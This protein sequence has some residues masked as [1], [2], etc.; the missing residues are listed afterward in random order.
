MQD[1]KSY[2]SNIMQKFYNHYNV[3]TDTALADKMMVSRSAVAQWRYKKTIPKKILSKYDY[4]IS[5]NKTTKISGTGEKVEV[6]NKKITIKENEKVNIESNYIIDLQKDKIQQQAT[7]II[8][9]KDALKRKQAE[10][11]HWEHLAY[12]FIASVTLKRSGIKFARVINSVSNLKKQSEIL[13]YSEKELKVLWD[14]GSQYTMEKHPIDK[15]IN[16]E[17][18][19]EIQKQCLTLPIVFDAM[20]ASV[21]D[22]YIPQ[23]IMYTHKDGHTIGAISYNKIKWSVLGIDSKV[24]FLTE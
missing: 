10:S 3:Y 14:I 23:P 4:I 1:K 18:Q 9:L 8:K 15:I 12:D 6:T 19:K 20:K 7:E 24:Q 22:H 11:A 2:F 17:T 13:G 16:K 5:P 21:G